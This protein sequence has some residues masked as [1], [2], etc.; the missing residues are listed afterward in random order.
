MDFARAYQT[1][2]DIGNEIIAALP[3]LVLAFL[4]F[5]VFYLIARRIRQV[6]AYMTDRRQKGK[7]L[8]LILGRLAQS[9]VLTIGVLMALTIV[10]RS[11]RH[12]DLI[13]L[14]GIGSVPIGFAFHDIFQNFLAGILL[15][16]AAPFKI[17]DQ[18]QVEDF[19]GT[20][21]DIHTRA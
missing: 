16:L 5:M 11:F 13:Q 7:H 20:V 2:L 21:E 15:L 9:A 3:N 4:L 12:G 1:L 18:I 19:E 10:C 14:L 6:V 17:N 8:G